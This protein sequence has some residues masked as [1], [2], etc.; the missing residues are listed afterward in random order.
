MA[1]IDKLHPNS[2]V[3]LDDKGAKTNLS[4]DFYKT[5]RFEV[6]N[7]TE[8]QI[9]LK[10]MLK[11]IYQINMKIFYGK[12]VYG[13]EEIQASLNVLKKSLTL[14]DG[15]SVKILEKNCNTLV[16]ICRICKFW[17]FSKFTALAS[18][19]QKGSEIITPTLTFSTTVAPITVIHSF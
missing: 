14:I 6:I 16:K 2:L 11:I 10:K 7:E 13:K 1:S 4:I 9:F 3:L 8:N 5:N 17:F 18:L 15:P 12:A 19:N